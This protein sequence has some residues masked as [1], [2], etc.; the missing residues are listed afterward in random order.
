[1][2]GMVEMQSWFTHALKNKGQADHVFLVE[3]VVQRVGKIPAKLKTIF[4]LENV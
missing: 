1:M 3:N 4:N 2:D